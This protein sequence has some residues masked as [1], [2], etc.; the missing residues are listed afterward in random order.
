[1]D[2]IR[3]NLENKVCLC[4]ERQK[5]VHDNHAKSRD[6][7]VNHLRNYG[8]GDCCKEKLLR[9]WDQL[10]MYFVLLSDGGMSVSMQIK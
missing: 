6:F 10:Y 7:H 8:S 9:N 1:M 4:Q 5:S 2:S 3:P